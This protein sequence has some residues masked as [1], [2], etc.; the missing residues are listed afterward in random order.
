MT[1]VTVVWRGGGPRFELSKLLEQCPTFSGDRLDESGFN[2]SLAEDL[3][4]SELSECLNKFLSQSRAEIEAA[5]VAGAESVIDLA[6]FVGESAP[7]ASLVV[8]A[9]LLS[10][11]ASAELE[12]E[13]SAYATNEP[14]SLDVWVRPSS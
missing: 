13:V 4:A 10:L 7:N 9:P 11:L 8:S 14:G 3:P 2:K 1:R 12:L 6:L 5:R